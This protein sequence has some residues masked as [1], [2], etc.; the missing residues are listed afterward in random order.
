MIKL[1]FQYFCATESRH[2]WAPSCLSWWWV[3]GTPNET[4][5]Q[6]SLLTANTWNQNVF[7]TFSQNSTICC[8]QR[9]LQKKG[10]FP[11]RH[12]HTGVSNSNI[13]CHA[14]FYK[15]WISTS[16]QCLIHLNKPVIILTCKYILKC[17]F[18]PSLLWFL[19]GWWGWQYFQTG[20][21]GASFDLWP[22][23]PPLLCGSQWLSRERR[24]CSRKQ[25]SHTEPRSS[26]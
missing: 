20:S 3:L 22:Q 1:C 15:G 14:Q 18:F 11:F 10:V 23:L 25:G 9:L 5:G 7:P 24:G 4:G 2:S 12:T 8:S 6:H 26:K 19:Y 17:W 13:T 21:S 16:Q